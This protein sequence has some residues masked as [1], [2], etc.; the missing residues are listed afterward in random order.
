MGLQSGRSVLLRS[1]RASIAPRTAPAGAF[2]LSR[3]LPSNVTIRH[4]ICELTHLDRS[5]LALLFV[6]RDLAC[7]T[8][9]RIPHDDGNALSVTHVHIRMW[10]AAAAN[11][12]EPVG[13]MR[14]PGIW[15]L[16]FQELGLRNAVINPFARVDRIARIVAESRRHV[17]ASSLW[18]GACKYPP[19][20]QDS[21]GRRLPRMDYD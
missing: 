4:S 21:L 8:I 1:S 13:H 16:L 5:D 17:E 18:R 6:K 11:A 7:E 3:K 19:A 9:R 14:R 10:L 20:A 12:I 15:R 2:I